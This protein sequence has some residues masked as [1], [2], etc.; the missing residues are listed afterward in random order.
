[1]LAAG[2]HVY[3]EWPLGVN[4][5]EATA[6]ASLAKE[7][8]VRHM[9]GLQGFGAPGAREVAGL[10]AD[11]AIGRVCAVSLVGSGGPHGART[12]EA[13]AYTV[14]ASSGATILSAHSGHWLAALETTVGPIRS[15]SALLLTVNPETIIEGTGEKR[16]VT[17]PDQ[18][19]F[20]GVLEGG[21]LVSFTAQSGV[22]PAAY[23]FE[24]RIVGTDGTLVL[25]PARPQTGDGSGRRHDSFHFTDWKLTLARPDGTLEE[26]FL[27][28]DG[29]PSDIPAGPPRNIAHLYREFARAITEK[30]NATPDFDT[31]VRFHKLTDVIEKSSKTQ[32][33][34]DV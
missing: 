3:C 17:A 24:A 30:R 34:Q 8:D 1:V 2:K 25:T 23:G 9:I 4:T 13:M 10:I 19:S 6:L 15:L 12:R 29:L 21:A 32:S 16:R 33:R 27:A 5:A 31:A 28:D 22:A 26:R 20:S 14:E 7:A 18:V 11:G